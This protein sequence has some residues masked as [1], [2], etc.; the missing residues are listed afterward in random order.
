MSNPL[1]GECNIEVVNMP[2][3][4]SKGIKITKIVTC[5]EL[6][7]IGIKGSLNN[8]ADSIKKYAEDLK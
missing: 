4:L 1:F 7:E 6:E 5:E 3:F 8:I 2:D